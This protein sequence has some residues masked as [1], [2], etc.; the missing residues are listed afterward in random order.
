M[1]EKESKAA[2]KEFLL[3]EYNRFADLF[4]R[5]EQAGETRVNWFIGIVTAAIGGLIVLVTKAEGRLN[6]E[7]LRLI[8]VTGLAAVLVFGLVTFARMLIRNEKTDEYKKSLDTIR[9]RFQDYLDAD[10]ILWRYYPLDAP[11]KNEPKGRRIGGLAHIVAAINAVM[12]AGV[13]GVLLYPYLKEGVALLYLIA[14]GILGLGFAGQCWLAAARHE[15]ARERLHRADPTHAGGVVFEVTEKN[16]TRYLIVRPS[17]GTPKW[18]LPKGNI[19]PGEL[20]GDTALREVREETG[21]TARIVCPIETIEYC[22]KG[23]SD[24][25]ARQLRVK[26][27]LMEKFFQGTPKEEREFRWAT[28]DEAYADLKHQESKDVLQFG[29]GLR[30]KLGK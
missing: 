10:G 9:Q 26:F 5:N 27:Y 4:W 24:K 13:V 30:A 25:S 2:V 28:F 1:S 14:V 29:E 21:V 12:V 16:V 18:V 15:K 17:D 3:A 23:K 6:S 8:A 22:A 11:A 20:H 7:Q 19:K